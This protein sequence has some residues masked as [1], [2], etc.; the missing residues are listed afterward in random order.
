MTW[1]VIQQ[2]W[3]EGPAAIGDV[4]HERGIDLRIVRTDRGEPVPSVDAIDAYEG[5]I[6][7]GGAMGALDDHAHPSLAGQRALLA[8][9][10]ERDL[11]VLGVCLGAQLLAVAAG[12]EL[13]DG[14]N[15]SEDGI[16]TVALTEAGQ[17]D[18]VLGPLGDEFEALQW[19]EDTYAPPPEAVNLATSAQY[20]Q[21]AFRLGSCQ[22]G[23]QFHVEM[24]RAEIASLRDDFPAD[25]DLDPDRAERV[26]L[27]GRVVLERFFDRAAEVANDRSRG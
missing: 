20:P 7:L 23:L 3:F 10:V 26:V 4:A 19:H 14:H 27:A 9:A 25:A 15:G 18:P 24:G 12:G 11:P 1:L 16:S 22:Y 8:A 13:R 6:V 17:D 21:Q 5:L 2:M